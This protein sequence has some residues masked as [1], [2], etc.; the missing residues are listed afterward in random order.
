M[1]ELEERI[2]Q[3]ESRNKRVEV[4]KAW[5]V[6]DARRLLIA[7]ITYLTIVAFLKDIGLNHPWINAIVPVLGFLLS[8]LAIPW[9][10]HVWIRQFLD[11]S[12]K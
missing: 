1:K 3:L 4:D 12:K 2:T 8:T 7:A 5:E 10:K 6:S 11:R 9:C